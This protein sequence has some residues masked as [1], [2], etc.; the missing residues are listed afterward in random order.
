MNVT[1]SV[2]WIWILRIIL[3]FWFWFTKQWVLNLNDSIWVWFHSLSKVTD[4]KTIWKK[5]A[6]AQQSVLRKD[7]NGHAASST[8]LVFSSNSTNIERREYNQNRKTGNG[9]Q[10]ANV[11]RFVSYIYILT[12][13]IEKK[14][15]ARRSLAISNWVKNS[16]KRTNYELKSPVRRKIL[17]RIFERNGHV[18]MFS[19]F[20]IQN[21]NNTAKNLAL[22]IKNENSVRVH[23]VAAGTC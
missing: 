16:Q 10:I 17:Y 7:S 5:T 15:Y 12:V 11:T 13:R 2:P 23:G 6:S 22:K 19:S 1:P 8:Y 4:S 3:L 20:W 18:V 21:P 14:Y 9:K